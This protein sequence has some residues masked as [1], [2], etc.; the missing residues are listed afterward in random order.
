LREALGQNLATEQMKRRL[1]KILTETDRSPEAL[2]L[3]SPLSTGGDAGTL[4]LLGVALAES[5]R[6]SEAR[7]TFSRA[8]E[9]EAENVDV[10]F[11]LGTLSLRERD[12]ARAK[13]W[14]ERALRLNPR[15]PGTLTSLGQAQVQLGDEAGA[16]DSWTK[17]ISLDPRQYDAL[18]NLAVLAGRSGRY[19]QARKALE[20]FL[21]AAPPDR[22]AANIAEARRLLR[23][24]N[25]RK[26]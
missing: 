25:A 3:L 21:S 5:G 15:A 12:P 23:S 1:A 14:F 17:A 7:A 4:D 8:L 10:L 16:L 22:Y 11:H 6:L 26:S 20:R 13:D 2:T 9:L 24:L 18:F 19:G